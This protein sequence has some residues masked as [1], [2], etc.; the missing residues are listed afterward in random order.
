MIKWAELE[1]NYPDFSSRVAIRFLAHRHHVLASLRPDGSPRVSGINL[2]FNDGEMWF[3]SMTGSQKTRDL[4]RD[5]RCAVHSAPLSETL[6]SGDVK[7]NGVASRLSREQ[8][9]LWQPG[10][11]HD[12]DYFALLLTHVSLV[13]VRN[14]KLVIE[15]WDTSHGL[16]IVE[17][18]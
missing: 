9:L 2:F 3:G 17:R 14:E 5:P 4:L 18:L 15:M 10:S 1:T 13:T 16:R 8:A 6:E 12:G 7:I 11:P